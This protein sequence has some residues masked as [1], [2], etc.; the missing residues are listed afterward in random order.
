MRGCCAIPGR[1]LAGKTRAGGE[2]GGLGPR[3]DLPD[4][5]LYHP[6][7]FKGLF[8][9]FMMNGHC[10]TKDASRHVVQFFED[11][12]ARYDALIAFC[13]PPL[14]RNE[15][16][17]L[18]V[19]A[20]HGRVLESRLRRMGLNVEAA[21]ACGQL[22]VADAVSM[23]DSIMV[24]N[25][26]DAIRFLDSV[27]GVLRDMVARYSQIHI[28]GEMVDLLWGAQNRHAALELES[29]CND[30]GVAYEL[31]IFCGYSGEYFTSPEDRG[32]LRELHGLHTHVVSAN[33]RAKACTHYP[34][35]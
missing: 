8:L 27:D 7:V 35:D 25:T 5:A 16:V 33:D 18:V 12:Q 11:D 32:Y 24:Q 3:L 15:G 10:V 26:P 4:Q 23:L 19:T 17:L 1:S 28:Y 21:R 14:I 29:L 2:G 6:P 31:K 20:E 22:R 34:Q 9:D 13:Y 30:L